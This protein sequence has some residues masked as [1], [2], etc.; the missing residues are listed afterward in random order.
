MRTP[1]PTSATLDS[2]FAVSSADARREAKP[3]R[4]LSLSATQDADGGARAFLFGGDK[5][6]KLLV[7]HG[8]GRLLRLQPRPG[9][10]AVV[11]DQNRHPALEARPQLRVEHEF[12]VRPSPAMPGFR[13]DGVNAGGLRE[14]KGGGPFLGP[15]ALSAEP[16]MEPVSRR[17]PAAIGCPD[18]SWTSVLAVRGRRDSSSDRPGSIPCA[19]RSEAAANSRCR[20][21]RTWRSPGRA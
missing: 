9:E 19:A 11:R 12:A 10:G 18:R 2:P 5:P 4:R 13:L 14:S 8:I 15:A 21:R 17:S 16:G 3:S 7:G 6:R 20:C 1:P